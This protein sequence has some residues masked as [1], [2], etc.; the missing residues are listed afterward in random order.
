MKIKRVLVS[1]PSP[2][3]VEKSPYYALEKNHSMKV[4]YRKFIKIEGLSSR[5]F[6][7]QRINIMDY[8]AI[9]FTSRHAVDN[10]FRLAKETRCEIPDSM[11][12]LCISEAAALYLQNYVQYRKRKIFHANQMMSDLKALVKKHKTE[13]FLFPASENSTQ[14]TTALLK[15]KGINIVSANMY[16]TVPEDLNDLEI[17]NYDLI[18]LFSPLGVDSLYSNFPDFEQGDRIIGAL[19]KN[20]QE[21]VLEKK[22]TL[23]IP[24][25]TKTAPS[26]IKAVEEYLVKRKKKK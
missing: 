9:I 3:D 2:P 6:R 13:K 10:F 14:D 23:E 8:S 17:N 4:D 20:T 21:A 24:A 11:K 5:E 7:Q 16:R 26:M 19:G 1:Q 22:L 18:I 25:P 12:Y 15:D